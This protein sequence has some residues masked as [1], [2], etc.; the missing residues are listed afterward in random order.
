[1]RNE[2]EKL[3]FKINDWVTFIYERKHIYKVQDIRVEKESTLHNPEGVIYLFQLVRQKDGFQIEAEQE[4]LLLLHRP[5]KSFNSEI[6]EGYTKAY[7]QIQNP[8]A[9]PTREK[10]PIGVDQYLDVYNDYH[11]LY[12]WFGDQKYLEKMHKV[13]N[14]MK[15]VYR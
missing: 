12:Q 13:L 7:Y 8:Q 2:M 11:L 3:Q 5:V 6:L 15:T 4:E 10:K 9:I 14:K 1:M